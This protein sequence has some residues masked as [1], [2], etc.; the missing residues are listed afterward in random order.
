M[1]D[2]SPTSQPHPSQRRATPPS[3]VVAASLVAVEAVLLVVYGVLELVAVHVGRLTMGV[4]TSAFFMAYGLVL[5]FCAR[6][7]LRLRSWARAPV[8]L[9][10]LIQVLVGWGFRGP[11]TTWVAV[12]MVVIGVLVLVGIFHPASVRALSRETG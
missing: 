5:L 3:L 8:V 6:A 12:A 1:D 10:Q 4:T 11:G 7:L 9:A 2:S